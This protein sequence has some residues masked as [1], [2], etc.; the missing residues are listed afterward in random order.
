MQAKEFINYI[1]NPN[2]LEKES[3]KELQKLVND[4]PY[5]QSAHLLLSLASKKWDASVYQK[6]LKK[7][8]I[9]VT[10]R[11]YLFN[12]IQK[13]DI[14][15]I[16]IE[17]SDHQKLVV[18]EVLEPI[19]STKELNILKATE[20][21]IENS[22][23]EISETGV[24]QKTKPNAEDVLENEIAKQVVGAIVEK[25]MFNLS[26][27]Q[28]LFKQNKEPETFTDWL[29]L[30]QKSNKQ[31]SGENILDTN[32]ENNTDIKTRLEKGK[33]ITQESALNKKLKNL[34]LIDK[35]IENSPGQIKIKDDQKFYSP[36]H[37]A[38][39]S[40]L[41]NE[42][43]VSETLAKIY[44]LQGSVNKAVRAYE[45][46]SLKFPQKSAYFASLIQKLKNN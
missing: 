26:D 25:Q 2:S 8:A 22:D 40:L 24:Q 1:K 10:N 17:D 21:L 41:E 37:N 45:I 12:L 14:S 6:S 9:V 44:A 34:A 43:L 46:L 4:F 27:T 5:F 11:S 3:V 35:I 36:E 19:D 42:H 13:V 15:N 20:L 33:I 31:L 23:S 18:E 7:T 39:E 16:V 29:R 30:I 32:I 38:K 28:L